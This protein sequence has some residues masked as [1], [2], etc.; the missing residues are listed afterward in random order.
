MLDHST[1]FIVDLL[2]NLIIDKNSEIFCR[3]K[4]NVLFMVF[5]NSKKWF[6]RRREQW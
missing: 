1:E 4:T 6:Q 2:R 5:Y 3:C